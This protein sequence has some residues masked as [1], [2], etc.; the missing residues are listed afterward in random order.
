MF[1]E[2]PAKS[3]PAADSDVTAEE[4]LDPENWDAMRQ[5]GH[6]MVDD[7][8]TYLQTVRRRPVWQPIPDRIRDELSRPLP[9]EPQGAQQTYQDFRDIVLPHPM[10]NIHPRF[11]GWVIGTGTPFGAL[12][13]ML[14]AA[15]NPNLGGAE[16]VPNLVEIQVIDWCKQMLG[17]DPDASGLLVSGGS[18]ANLVG[19]TVARNTNAEFDV[20]SS[21]LRAAP[22]P[23]TLYGSVEMHSSI[24]KAVE[25]LGLGS[26]ALVKIP[27]D[28]RYRIELPALEAAVAE[29]R[30]AGRYPF[31]VVGNAGTVNTGAFDN[32]NR[33]AEFAHR[34]KMWFHVDGAFGA[35]AAVSKDLQYLVEGMGKADSIAFDLHK[36]MYM[37]IEVGCVLVRSE[38]AHRRAF[39]LTP[40]YLAHGGDRG[41]IAGSRWFSD[42]GIQLSRGFR[43]LKVWMS[44]KEHGIERYGRI[45]RQNTRQA[46]YLAELVDKAPELQRLAPVPLNIVCFRYIADGL[47]EEALNRLNQEILI[48]LHEKGVAAPSYT[49]LNGKYAI[50][51]AIVNHRSRRED[52]E[53]LVS[54]TIRLGAALAGQQ[55][56]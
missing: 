55:V 5:L 34:E 39:S 45:I 7:I 31:C 23:M 46:R 40:E 41:L 22:R 3:A 10:G 35:L 9:I 42:Y 48:Q 24:Q 2:N 16:H 6:E 20:R 43:A 44:L 4:T 11:W 50:R 17:Y 56:S 27:V 52:F 33:L 14:A 47:D 21:G 15:M 8:M 28:D 29:D 38:A 53:L 12:A 26:Q 37:P 18:M 30:A 32:L 54:E 51:A 25:L 19:L 36:W 49:T 13:E 1:H